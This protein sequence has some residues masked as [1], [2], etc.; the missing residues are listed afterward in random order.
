MATVRAK[1][2]FGG[3]VWFDAVDILNALN[4]VSI[5]NPSYDTRLIKHIREQ[6]K[7]LY[8]DTL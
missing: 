6:L 8:K 4:E 2:S 1:Q 5:S 3:R 7:D